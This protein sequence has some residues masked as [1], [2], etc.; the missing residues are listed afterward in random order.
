MPKRSAGLM[1]YRRMHE[2]LE[3]FLVHPGGPF[4][5]KKDAGSWTIPKGEYL[6]GEEALAAAQREFTEETGFAARGPFLPLGDVKQKSGKIVS[7]WAFEGDCDPEKLV[8]NTCMIDWPP[9]SGGQM[10]IPEIDRGEW[11]AI[12]AAREKIRAEQLSF[13]ERLEDVLGA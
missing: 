9:R 2:E 1:L 12:E 4:W 6:D 7:G 11:F 8:S 5:V 3:V 13:L 10:E